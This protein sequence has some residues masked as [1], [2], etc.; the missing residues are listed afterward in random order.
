MPALD[1]IFNKLL[2]DEEHK[3][4]KPAQ[5]FKVV[6]DRLAQYTTSPQS[7][8]AKFYEMLKPAQQVSEQ[9]ADVMETT[10]GMHLQYAADTMPKDPG[11]MMMM[12]KSMWVPTDRQ[13]YEWG[14]R[15]MGT[16]YPLDTVDMVADGLV[17]PQ[18]VEALRD[19]NP[20]TFAKFQ[21]QVIE[22]I[23]AIRENST[24]DQR[25]SL[26]LAFSLPLDPTTDPR[27]VAFMQSM[28]AQKSMEQAAGNAA[29][30]KTPEEGYSDAQ[31]LLA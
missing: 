2:P 15:L 16:M 9:L 8:S 17:P 6:Q 28:H 4:K 14:L 25:I 20:G 21:E 18:A 22:N 13:L 3:N 1:A 26:G 12:G 11:T 5:K 30:T 10:L 29:E 19:T 23:D 31:K 24:Y 7:F 27:Y